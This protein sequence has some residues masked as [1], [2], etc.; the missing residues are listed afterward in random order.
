MPNVNHS[1]IYFRVDLTN[2][3]I[4]VVVGINYINMKAKYSMNGQLLILPIRGEGPANI[5]FSTY[6]SLYKTTGLLSGTYEYRY[7]ESSLNN[8][9]ILQEYLEKLQMSYFDIVF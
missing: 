7:L 5:T 1:I 8:L 3:H 6:H 4:S 9:A 2:K